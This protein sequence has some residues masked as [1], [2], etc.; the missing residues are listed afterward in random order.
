MGIAIGRD[1]RGYRAKVGLVCLLE[2]LG[3]EVVDFGCYGIQPVDYP[4]VARPLAMAVRTS[5]THEVIAKRPRKF[6]KGKAGRRDFASRTG[7]KPKQN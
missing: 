5:I 3:H 1:H 4:D 6:G 2:N 7:R